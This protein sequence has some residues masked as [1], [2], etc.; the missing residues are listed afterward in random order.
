MGVD[1]DDGLDLAKP[2]L[3]NQIPM[4]EMFG[5]ERIKMSTLR[6]HILSR[7]ATQIL[8]ICLFLGLVAWSPAARADFV[9]T[10]D[11]TNPNTEPYNTTFTADVS[12]RALA[13]G[14]SRLTIDLINT[15][16]SSSPGGYITGFAFSTPGQASYISGSYTTTNSNFSLLSGSVSTQPYP[17]QD[18]G[19]ALGGSWVGGGSPTGGISWSASGT[20]QAI[21]TYDFSGQSLTENQ[22]KDAMLGTSSDP[23]FLVRFRGLS[24]GGSN[25]VP[26]VIVPEPTSAVLLGL[27]LLGVSLFGVR[28]YRSVAAATE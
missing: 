17:S 1:L 9:L 24:G 28:R 21:F 15:T 13:N 16:T 19:G 3:R 20:N 27:S 12:L 25:K 10:S 5:A 11:L 14:N 23:G 2:R 6:P 18:L 4:N 8:G 26:A 7:S 22:F